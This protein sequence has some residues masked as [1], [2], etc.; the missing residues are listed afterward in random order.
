VYGDKVRVVF[1][2]FPLGFHQKAQKAA[3]AAECAR[4]QGK[5]WEYH[6]TM[7]GNQQALEPD[8]LKKYATDVGLKAEQFNACLDSGKYAEAVQADMKDGQAIGVSGTPAFFV[9]GRFV[10]GALPYEEFEK[11]VDEE[12]TLKGIPIPKKG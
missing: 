12:L 9:N 11:I 7:F 6:D 10:S 8:N 1:R 5:F 2:H 3:E 4:E